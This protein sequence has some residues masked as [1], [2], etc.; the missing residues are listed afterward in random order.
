[1]GDSFTDRY[2]L[3]HF[4]SGVIARF[5]GIHKVVW[6]LIH[7]L[8][9]LVENSKY[10][11]EFINLLPF[12]PGGKDH[13]DSWNNML[14]DTFYA[15]LGHYVAFMLQEAWLVVLFGLSLFLFG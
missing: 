4:G 6:L 7:I 12:W 15:V 2:S 8:F 13:A 3:L 1:M 14:G 5:L 9:E 10:G 11:M